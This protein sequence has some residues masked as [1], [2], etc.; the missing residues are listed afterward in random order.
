MVEALITLKSLE[1]PRR[2]TDDGKA[3]EGEQHEQSA[4]AQERDE[5]KSDQ[6]KPS[7]ASKDDRGSNNKLAS[8]PS[9]ADPKIGNAISH[10]QVLDIWRELKSHDELCPSLETILRGSHV[11]IP[12]PPP[13]PEPASLE[14][15]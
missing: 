7:A 9:L 6:I 10:R 3:I 12:P 8:E 13:K 1:V 15:P 11:Y 2:E 14:S 4:E 5:A